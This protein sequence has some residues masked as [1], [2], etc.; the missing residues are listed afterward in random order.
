MNSIGNFGTLVITETLRRQDLKQVFINGE[1]IFFRLFA[2]THAII[3]RPVSIVL[4]NVWRLEQLFAVLATLSNFYICNFLRNF[5]AKYRFREHINH[6]KVNYFITNF[7]SCEFL[8]L[9]T[10]INLLN[11]SPFAGLKRHQT[12]FETQSWSAHKKTQE[13]AKG[14]NNLKWKFRFDYR[15]KE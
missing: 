3:S 11:E 15:E 10:F 2:Q 1:H 13:Y 8:T 12:C 5:W 14:K 9:V 4:D 6:G 7:N